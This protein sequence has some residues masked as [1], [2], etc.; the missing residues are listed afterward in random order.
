VEE[1]QLQ[2]RDKEVAVLTEVAMQREIAEVQAAM[3]IAKRFPRNHLQAIDRITIVCQ[4][5][6]LAEGALYTYSRGGTEVTGP[7]IR[8]AEAIAQQWGNMQFG[9][10]ELEQRLAESTVEAYAWDLETN[11]RENKVFQVK[12]TRHTRRGSYLL[13]DPRDIYEMVANQGA[14]RLRACILGIIPG[15]VV[16][17]AVNQCEIT[18]KAKADTSPEALQK[19]VV[20]FGEIGVSQEMLE[21]RIQRK[22]K[23]ITPA[24]VIGLR[25]IYNS[26]KDGMS[27][28]A[29][30]FEMEPAPEPNGKKSAQEASGVAVPPSPAH[31][32]TPPPTPEPTTAPSTQSQGAKKG[33][34]LTLPEVMDVCEKQTHVE[35]PIT[36][37]TTKGVQIGQWVDRYFAEE[38]SH[39]VFEMRP[40]LEE[41]AQGLTKDYI[42]KSFSESGRKVIFQAPGTEAD[43]PGTDEEEP[44]PT[45]PPEQAQAQGAG[46]GSGRKGPGKV[47]F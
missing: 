34:G 12:H 5:L 10:R 3:T 42:A 45:T 15:D 36:L 9:I 23:N 29:D 46:A 8:L 4:R 18:L 41:V 28:P 44:L 35:L 26:I 37:V 11:V 24:Q 21:Q 39:L 27:K 32:T 31:T 2:T 1:N 40:D 43:K 20:V 33:D 30:W 47:L 7:S 25:K 16:E 14:R 19:M 6:A 38:M 17:A 22:L 13:K